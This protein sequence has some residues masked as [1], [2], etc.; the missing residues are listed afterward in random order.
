MNN[1]SFLPQ[2]PTDRY[3]PYVVIKVVKFDSLKVANI[4]LCILFSTAISYLVHEINE[5]KW[6]KKVR[7]PA[8]GVVFYHKQWVLS[9]RGEFKF[10]KKEGKGFED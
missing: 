6:N 9:K 1:Q 10:L 2:F 7:M 3:T 5:H 4:F 8:N